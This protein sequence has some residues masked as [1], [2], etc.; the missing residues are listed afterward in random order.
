MARYTG[1]VCKLCRREGVK[2]FLKGDKCLG[3]RCT[4]TKRNA[5]PP[6]MHGLS[7]RRRISDYGIQLRAKQRGRRIFGVLE[8]QFH[9]YFDAAAARKG[10]TGTV[11]LQMLERRLDNVVYRAGFASSRKEAR[12][13]VSHRHFQV[14]G[15]MVNIPAFQVKPGQVITVRPR[16]R[17][18]APINRSLESRG[19]QTLPGWMTLYPD[20]RR[21][22]V[23]R[24]P[25]RPEMDTS[26]DE[27]LIVEWYSR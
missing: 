12:Q 17:D 22:D 15:R 18:L 23:T 25:E 14:D 1:P 20:E 5:T 19:G 24:L 8:T 27:Q 2:L 10:V 7:R 6:G 16:S 26:I 9:N 13:L 21:V 4:F 3:E 11:L